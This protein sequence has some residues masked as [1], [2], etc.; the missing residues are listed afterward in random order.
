LIQFPE[1]GSS[2]ESLIHLTRNDTLNGNSN[3]EYCLLEV[4]APK[5]YGIKVSGLLGQLVFVQMYSENFRIH[6]EF[7]ST[8]TENVSFPEKFFG[9]K[10][11][12]AVENNENLADISNQTLIKTSL[13]LNAFKCITKEPQ[14]SNDVNCIDAKDVIE[15]NYESSGDIK[16]YDP[17]TLCDEGLTAC[18]NGNCIS[19]YLFCN[20]NDDCGDNSDET[21]NMCK[22]YSNI[23]PSESNNFFFYS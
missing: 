20:H 13:A 15:L 14:T 23:E 5:G 10:L 2:E 18:A 3:L 7:N 4:T 12:I 22:S 16:A 17:E 8:I 21:D 9:N 11:L 6:F 19:I 1:L